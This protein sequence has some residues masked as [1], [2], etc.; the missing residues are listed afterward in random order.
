MN[1][2]ADGA[3]TGT[4]TREALANWLNGAMEGPD[5]SVRWLEN[6]AP[7]AAMRRAA[8]GSTIA[9]PLLVAGLVLALLETVMARYFSH[10][11]RDTTHTTSGE[12]AMA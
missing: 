2:D 7:G 11:F 1:A 12:G 4:V 6:D 5:A 10:A 3:R 9:W 8:T